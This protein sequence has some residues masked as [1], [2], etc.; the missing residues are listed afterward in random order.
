MVSGL[1][2]HP[3]FT[4]V[5]PV[6]TAA[7]IDGFRVRIATGV[8]GTALN[9]HRQTHTNSYKRDKRGTGDYKSTSLAPSATWQVGLQTGDFTWSYP[10]PAPVPTAAAES[11]RDQWIAHTGTPLEPP[12]AIAV[13][14]PNLAEVLIRAWT[15][16][17][18]LVPRYG[19]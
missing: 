13:H 12:H 19:H 18:W 16:L 5:R 3:I 6:R 17:H 10:L 8:V 7:E 1:P 4:R 14:N 2:R 11:P 15:S 9:V